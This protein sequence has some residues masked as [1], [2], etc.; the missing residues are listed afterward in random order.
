MRYKI[1]LALLVFFLAACSSNA[2]KV[3]QTA[4]VM[5]QA[6]EN[7]A[8]IEKQMQTQVVISNQQMTQD[9]AAVSLD[10][11]RVAIAQ[12]QSALNVKE[13]IQA[14]IAQTQA[15]ELIAG[16]STPIPGSS[17]PAGVNPISSTGVDF[18]DAT[19]YSNAPLGSNKRL[20]TIQLSDKVK[21]ITGTYH[22]EVA[23]KKMK[24]DTVEAYPNRLYCSG[25]NPRGGYHAVRLYEDLGGGA[26]LVFVSDIDLPIWTPTYYLGKKA[27]ATP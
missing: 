1:S 12:T 15:A 9:A 25:F 8:I 3:I 11:T 5:T 13:Q 23:G 22:L 14:S 2:E 27:S 16:T 17:V 10:Q 7:T 20:I 24:C 18:N 26:I 4:I 19:V 21:E 6:F